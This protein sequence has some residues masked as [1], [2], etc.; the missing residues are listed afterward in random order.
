MHHRIFTL[1]CS[2]VLTNHWQV[3]ETPC[4][5]TTS[6][7]EHDHGIPLDP[8]IQPPNV[9]PYSHHFSQNDQIEKI[10]HKCLEIDAIYPSIIPY[11]S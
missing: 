10:I 5:L 4:G 1:I 7:G 6:Y 8:M 11:S 9:P 3:F 2:Q